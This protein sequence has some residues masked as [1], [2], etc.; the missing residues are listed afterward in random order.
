[1][2]WQRKETRHQSYDIN[3]S[4]SSTGGL[5]DLG[6]VHCAIYATDRPFTTEITR[7]TTAR[8]S[9][10]NEVGHNFVS[11]FF[12][13]SWIR[14]RARDRVRIRT[15]LTRRT[16]VVNSSAIDDFEFYFKF[17]FLFE[18][19]NINQATLLIVHVKLQKLVINK[20]EIPR[21]LHLVRRWYAG[22]VIGVSTVIICC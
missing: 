16:V 10:D 11:N 18:F 20:P 4:T 9:A 3:F 2:T 8:K 12:G 19:E 22:N 6:L 21:M 5:W 14:I 1:M 15:Q 7:L 13:C 17:Q